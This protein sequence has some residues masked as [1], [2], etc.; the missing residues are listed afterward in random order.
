MEGQQGVDESEAVLAVE[1]LD[2]PVSVSHWVLKE[3]SNI[4]ERSP[5]LGIVPWLHSSIDPLCQVAVSGLHQRPANTVSS[6]G[7]LTWRSCQHAR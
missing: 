1:W 3:A 6:I 2:L 7:P 4:F 5:F